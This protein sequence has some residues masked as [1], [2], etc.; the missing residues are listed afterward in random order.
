MINFHSGVQRALRDYF[1]SPKAPA[2]KQKQAADLWTKSAL[3]QQAVNQK[4]TL[5]GNA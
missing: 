2:R 3:G 4:G 5:H 1:A